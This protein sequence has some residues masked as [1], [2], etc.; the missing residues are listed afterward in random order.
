MAQDSTS[1]LATVG[2]ANNKLPA[3]TNTL[4][5]YVRAIIESKALKLSS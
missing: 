1:S 5:L 4:K 3:P 2:Q